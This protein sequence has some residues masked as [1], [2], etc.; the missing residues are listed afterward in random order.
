MNIG[1]LG[2]FISF[3]LLT[4][5]L[6][7]SSIYGAYAVYYAYFKSKDERQKFIVLRSTAHAFSI[8]LIFYLSYYILELI[9]TAANVNQLTSLWNLLHFGMAASNLSIG[10]V[11]AM[12]SVLGICLFINKRKTGGD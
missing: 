5:V 2:Y 4:L 12:M 9:V 6:W 8:L 10:V 11:S 1:Q 3:V 7:I